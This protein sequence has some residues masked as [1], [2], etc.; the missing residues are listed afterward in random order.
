MELVINKSGQIRCLYDESIDL[1]ALGRL[2][3]TRASHVEPDEHGQWMA[4]LSPL[5]TETLGPFAKRSQALAAEQAWLARHWLIP[6]G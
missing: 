5:A 1:S 3:I 2:S 4:D 6:Q